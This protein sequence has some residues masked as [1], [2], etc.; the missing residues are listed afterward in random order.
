MGENGEGQVPIL[1]GDRTR[2]LDED[3]NSIYEEPGWRVVRDK[4]GMVMWD[5]EGR[6]CIE[7]VDEDLLTIQT[8]SVHKQVPTT[9]A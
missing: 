6:L 3:G 9:A 2:L 8:K 7:E 5:N 4:H 1:E